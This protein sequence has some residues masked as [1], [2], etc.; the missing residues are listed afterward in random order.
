MRLC[1]HTD[2]GRCDPTQHMEACVV[3]QRC[4]NMLLYMHACIDCAATPW[5]IQT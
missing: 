5:N 4:D 2:M 3:T 1:E